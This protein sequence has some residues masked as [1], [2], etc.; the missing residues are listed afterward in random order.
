MGFWFSF[1]HSFSSFLYF[2]LFPLSSV[3][4]GGI[5]IWERFCP[6]LMQR[7]REL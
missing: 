7:V 5:V 4:F 2:S 6:C 1:V 3:S